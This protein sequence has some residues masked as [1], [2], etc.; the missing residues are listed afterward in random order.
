MYSDLRGLEMR[1]LHEDGLVHLVG[2]ACTKAHNDLLLFVRGDEP[3]HRDGIDDEG[4]GHTREVEA[5]VVGHLAGV[6]DKHLLLQDLVVQDTAEVQLILVNPELQLGGLPLEFQLV[7]WPSFRLTHGHG[8]KLLAAEPEV[9][10]GD[11]LAASRIQR[12]HDRQDV[13]DLV[14][15]HRR[16]RL[17]AA[18]TGDAHHRPAVEL[19]GVWH[20]RAHGSNRGVLHT[21]RC[22]RQ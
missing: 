10:E 15:V 17:Q 2:D 8:L 12:A 16:G 3:S 20:L 5:E 4:P 9:R 6:R 18:G 19:G 22:V 13:E 14:D 1:D 11:D 21:L 7:L